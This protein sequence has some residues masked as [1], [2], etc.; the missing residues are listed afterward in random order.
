MTIAISNFFPQIEHKKLSYFEL[1]QR[2]GGDSSDLHNNFTSEGPKCHQLG[3]KGLQRAARTASIG[4]RSPLG[5]ER[6]L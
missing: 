1:N 6:P 5:P 3:P 4:Q 2:S